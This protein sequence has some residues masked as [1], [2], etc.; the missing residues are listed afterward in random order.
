MH[1][2]PIINGDTPLFFNLLPVIIMFSLEKSAIFLLSSTPPIPLISTA[3][4]LYSFTSEIILSIFLSH[5]PSVEKQTFIFMSFTVSKNQLNWI[6]S[7]FRQ[8]RA[9]DQKDIFRF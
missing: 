5:Q 8:A 6:I 1:D 4:I 3:F 9:N 7:Q 2:V